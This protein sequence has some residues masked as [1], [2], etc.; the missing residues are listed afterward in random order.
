M[1]LLFTVC[2]AIIKLVGIC[3]TAIDGEINYKL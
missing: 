1:I 2:Y 3:L